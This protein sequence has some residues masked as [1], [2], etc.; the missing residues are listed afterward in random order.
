MNT[1]TDLRRTVEDRIRAAFHAVALGRGVSSR[2][3][4]A[5]DSGARSASS[6]IEETNDWAQ[7]T[8]D[9]LERDCIA[10][11]DAEGFR[12]YIRP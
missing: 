6:D 12:Y 3:A 7:I 1:S 9:E 10:H 5:I 8:L 2:Q 4:Q 11:L